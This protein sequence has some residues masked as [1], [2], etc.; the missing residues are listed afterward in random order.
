[1]KVNYLYLVV[2]KESVWNVLQETWT[3][4]MKIETDQMFETIFRQDMMWYKSAIFKNESVM[5]QNYVY[6]VCSNKF[7]WIASCKSKPIECLK[8]SLAK[9]WRDIKGQYSIMKE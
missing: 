8:R 1:M 2:T 5:N 7:G 9:L 6:L 4:R 3:D